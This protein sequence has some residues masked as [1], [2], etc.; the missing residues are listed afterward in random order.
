MAE[1]FLGDINELY[2]IRFLKSTWSISDRTRTRSP[3]NRKRCIL[4]TRLNQR[5][6]FHWDDHGRF[7]GIVLHWLA[8]DAT[9]Y[10]SMPKWFHCSRGTEHRK[11]P[12]CGPSTSDTVHA[13]FV[14]QNNINC[15]QLCRK[16]YCI[17]NLVEISRNK[18]SISHRS[19]SPNNHCALTR[20]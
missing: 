19:L 17:A 11:L 2:W 20:F 5:S 18:R 7:V 16:Q 8:K 14:D 12:S 3:T 4:L 9:D 1:K 10:R 13:Y 15:D 6:S